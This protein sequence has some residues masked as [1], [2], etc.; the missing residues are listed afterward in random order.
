MENLRLCRVMA[1][2]LP[3]MDEA[4]GAGGG[5]QIGRRLC[6]LGEQ[7]ASDCCG[8]FGLSQM[9]QTSLAAALRTIG[10]F[11]QV[12]AGDGRKDFP[13]RGDN[14]R[15]KPQM[16][17]VVVDHGAGHGRTGKTE[18]RLSLHGLRHKG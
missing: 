16:A 6:Q 2:P 14:F 12:Q 5:Y 3:D 1:Q 8:Q 11:G 15:R 17:G 9:K 18:I 10:K 4:A 7:A 13:G